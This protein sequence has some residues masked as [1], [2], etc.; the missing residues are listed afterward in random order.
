MDSRQAILDSIRLIVRA[1]RVSS[2]STERRVG[3]SV[4]QLFVLQQL[5]ARDGLSINELARATLTHQSSVSV[6]VSKLAARRLVRRATSGQD[7]RR[8]VISLSAK[9]RLALER[10]PGAV[11]VRLI[12][13]LGA[14]SEDDV[15]R[16]ARLLARWTR[17]AGIAGTAPTLFGEAGRPRRRPA[18]AVSAPAA[19]S[20]GSPDRGGPHMIKLKR[21]YEEPSPEDGLRVLVDRLWPRGL[22][23]ER[24]SVDLWLKE[25]APSTDL[26]K[27]FGHEPAKWR[28]FEARYRRELREQK[29]A[30]ELLKEESRGHTVTLVYGARDEDHNEAVVLKAVL[31]HR[32]LTIRKAKPVQNSKA[33]GG[34]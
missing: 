5:Q 30:I 33:E 19:G 6:V 15:T 11:Q 25:V 8:T 28:E 4:A 7:R 16:L 20:S 23:K 13:G 2:A 21:V 18:G 32:K 29:R 3:I 17:A 1:V 31:E 26:R 12:A 24:A 9:G 27:W 10:A 14:L 22:T 34:E